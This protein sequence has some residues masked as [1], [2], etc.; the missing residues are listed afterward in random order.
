MRRAGEISARR[1]SACHARHAARAL[2]VRNRSRAAARIS[3]H[4]AQAPAYT[5]IVA[6][7]A[8]ACVLHYV[9]NDAQL[10]A[11]DLLLIDAGCE[12]DGYAS[13]ITRTFPVSGRFSGPQREV[14]ELVL[15]AQAAAIEQVKPGRLWEDPHDA[16]VRVLA[17]GLIDLGLCEGSVEAVHRVGRLQA[18]LHAPHRPLAG[19]GR[20]RRR[21]L[22]AR[23]RVAQPEA[24]HGADGRARLLRAS[25]RR[26]AGAVLEH[27]RAHRGRRAG[28]AG[29]LR[30]HHRAAPKTIERHRGA[31]AR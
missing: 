24:G 6:G 15:A 14:Y 11:G 31:D 20:A 12:L 22:Q 3:P 21:R 18:V 10:R 17:Q 5:P 4:G 29:R 13:D 28:D 23:R 19:H 30:D 16:A 1:P 25:R 9:E 7:G 26:R 27:R 8:N 2:R